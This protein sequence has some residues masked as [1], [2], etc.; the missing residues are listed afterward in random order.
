MEDFNRRFSVE[1]RSPEDA[2]RSVLYT[3]EEQR[4]ILSLHHDRKLSKNLTIQFKNKEYQLVGYGN[5]YRLR[6]AT[7]R[8]CEHFNGEITL[9]HQGKPLAF[10]VLDQGEKAAVIA[11]DKTLNPLIDEAKIKQKTRQ[12]WKPNIDHPW[13]NYPSQNL[14][15][16]K[17]TL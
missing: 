16:V 14:S 6:Q 8:I 15:A 3:K 17:A 9:L 10:R 2:H 12:P 11:D 4:L 1:P 7:V 5:G 13:R